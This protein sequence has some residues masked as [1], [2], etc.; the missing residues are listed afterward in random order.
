MPPRPRV[1][2]LFGLLAVAAVASL[3]VG[4][5]R[6]APSAVEDAAAPAVSYMFHTDVA[7]WYQA[8]PDEGV[9]LS[10]YNLSLD[11]LPA[12]LPM[13]MDSWHATDL[14]TDADIETWFAGPDL[15]LRRAYE[16]GT[17]RLVWLTA[18]GSRG[19]KS[20]RIFEH[21]P[22]TCYPSADWAALGESVHRVPLATGSLAVRRALFGKDG[23]QRLVYYWYQWDRASRDAL[24]GV[25][26]WRLTMD[27]TADEADTAAQL[28][29]FM[30]LLFHQAVAWHRF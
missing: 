17:G 30:G 2:A 7:G 21:T 12:T 11:A 23:Q 24:E 13:E 16:D 4:S 3:F 25:T 19:S 14:G 10:A 29:A 18:I 22:K 27:V 15:V 1:L 28:D 9:V 20:F 6:P 26:S 5:R 8:T